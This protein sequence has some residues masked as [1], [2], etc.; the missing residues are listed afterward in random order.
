M[1]QESDLKQP[2]LQMDVL[3]DVK[4]MLYQISALRYQLAYPDQKTKYCLTQ[5]QS[6]GGSVGSDHSPSKWSDTL[7]ISSS[8]ESS[9]GR[10]HSNK[11]KGT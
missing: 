1:I 6:A 2:P 5:Q 4:R 9:S 7:D 3:G 10:E 8:D 11:I